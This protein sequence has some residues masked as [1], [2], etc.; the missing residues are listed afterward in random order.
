M[1]RGN[2]QVEYT[3]NMRTVVKKLRRAGSSMQEAAAETLNS[4][5][6]HVLGRY[7]TL[8][9][10]RFKRVGQYTL[11][12]PRLYKAHHTRRNG[13]L[14]K[15]RDVNAMIGVPTPRGKNEHYLAKVE[16][17]G[18][19][20][21]SPR[22]GNKVPVPL[23]NA[24]KG[25]NPKAPIAAGNRMDKKPVRRMQHQWQNPRQMY[26]AMRAMARRGALDK[27]S[28]V[29]TAKGI[30][31]VAARRI[32][33]L[34]STKRSSLHY[35]SQPIFEESTKAASPRVVERIWIST[36]RRLTRRHTE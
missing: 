15:L 9:R 20:R 23:R 35:K 5:A 27:G 4:V 34:R 24:R 31:Q 21:G 3:D 8:M 26:G 25:G 28:W 33:M 1:S 22:A 19:R 6:G 10:S 14:R 17:G 32:K 13:E 2:V 18:V 11:N 7:K 29:Q 16:R 30:F 36:A 12:A